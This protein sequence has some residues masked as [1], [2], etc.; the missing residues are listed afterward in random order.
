MV[1]SMPDGETFQDTDAELIEVLKSLKTSIKIFG[2]GG[3]GSNTITRIMEEGIQGADIVAANTDAQHLLLTQASKK[4]LLG[5]RTTRG[6]GAG[7]I[8]QIGELSAREAELDIN[9]AVEGADIVFITAGMGGGTG[10]GSAPVVAE[11]AKN[12]G[13]LVISVVT[14]PF[15]SEGAMRKENALW[16]LEKLKEK[17]D[18]IVIIPNDKLLE[19]V[20]RLPLNEAFRFADETLMKSIKGLTELVTKPGLVNLDFNDLKTVMKDGGTA[21]I[22]MGQSGS[23]ERALEAAKKALNSPLLDLEVSTATSAIVSV[24]GSSNMS[25]EEAHAVL[26]EVRKKINPNAR[27]IWGARIDESMK[28]DIKVLAILVGAKNKYI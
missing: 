10:T 18:T 27:I 14:T 12:A 17:S 6:L 21:M 13:A 19:I 9:S 24:T 4:I 8:P 15:K 25:V 3:S 26:E 5:K 16:G 7:A 22:G 28:N 11:V 23:Q 20:P 1:V 2:C